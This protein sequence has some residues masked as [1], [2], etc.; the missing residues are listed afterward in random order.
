MARPSIT[1]KPNAGAGREL[2]KPAAQG[3]NAD[4]ACH[5]PVINMQAIDFQ[6]FLSA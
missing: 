2:H 4:L 5:K 6:R 3:A 1:G